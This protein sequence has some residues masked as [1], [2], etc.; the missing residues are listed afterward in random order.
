V[1]WA[2]QDADGCPYSG[3]ANILAANGNPSQCVPVSAGTFYFFGGWFRNLDA[4]LVTCLLQTYPEPNCEGTIGF[5]G[6][7]SGNEVAWTYKTTNIQIPPSVVSVRLVCDGNANS[8]VDKLFLT[9]PP[10]GY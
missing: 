6:N 7:I 10:G 8:Y 4:N 5:L 3:S 9:P 2:G 1:Q